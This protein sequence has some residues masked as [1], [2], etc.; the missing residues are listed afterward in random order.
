MISAKNSKHFLLVLFCLTCAYAANAQVLVSKSIRV[1]I[2]SSTPVEDIK[3][4]S[5]VGTA[6]L[7]T[8]KQEIAAQVA[9][10]S[11]EFDRKLMQ[12]HFNENYMESDK[13]PY[14]KFKGI[15]EPAIDWTKDGEYN[16]TV[17]GIL[18]AHGVDQAREIKGKIVVKN[19]TATINAGFDVA[20]A[21]HKIK[22]PSI[23]FTKVA[24]VIKLTIQGTLT[25]LNK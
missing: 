14:A 13:Y 7:V 21:D 12:E 20:C 18:N 25:T 5:S 19:G 11:F 17:K 10:K 4:A 2:F 24:E 1:N 16:V 8:Q 22:I 6:V 9:I 23:V 15:I 3:A